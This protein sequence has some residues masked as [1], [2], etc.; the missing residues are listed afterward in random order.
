MIEN[1]RKIR[2]LMEAMRAERNSRIR[3]R[4]RAVLGC[5][6]ATLQGPHLILQTRTGIR[7]NCGLPGSTKAASV[8]SSTLP[9]RAE[10]HAQGTVESRD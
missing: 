5:S 4:M 2:D 10:F 3:N 9:G 7:C 1:S 8:A 6:R